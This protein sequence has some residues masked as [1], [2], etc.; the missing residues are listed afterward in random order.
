[1]V[2]VSNISLLAVHSGAVARDC[3]LVARMRI[4]SSHVD[5]NRS[6]PVTD[7]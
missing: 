2:R 1:M 7:R 6:A 3:L 4:F 5:G